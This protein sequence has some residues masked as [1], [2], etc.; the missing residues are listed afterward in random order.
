MSK[1]TLSSQ[2]N[3]VPGTAVIVACLPSFHVL[4]TS[5]SSSAFNRRNPSNTN[6]RQQENTPRLSEV[7]FSGGSLRNI[8]HDIARW[9]SDEQEPIK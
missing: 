7:G 4:L 8:S 1:Q 9:V 6:R 3:N 2:L 5:R